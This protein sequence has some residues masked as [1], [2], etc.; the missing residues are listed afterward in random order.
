MESPPA[1]N[2]VFPMGLFR[3]VKLVAS[4]SVVVNDLF[5]TTK[6]LNADGTA[7][8][9]VSGTIKNSGNQDVA[10]TLD[11]KMA[12][13]N[14]AAEPLALPRQSINVH[15]G[16]N[17]FTREVVVKDPHLWWTWDLG[18]QNLYKLTATI[19]PAAGEGT[20][21]RTTVFGIRT[22]AR[23]SDMS[24]WLNGKR[25]FLK[26]A[27]YPIS[28]YYG[29]RPTRETYEKDLEMYKAANLNHLVAFTVVEKPD[30]YDLCDRLGI[31]EIFEFP[32]EQFG[33]IEVL[34]RFQPAPR[35]FCQGVAEPASADHC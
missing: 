32:F 14:F 26:G 33:P 24:Y 2:A 23:K 20:D 35:N 34:A 17:T 22:I 3:D 10:G 13:D 5:V 9:G 21:A 11:L 25:L 8:L 27:W 31:L 29:S 1:G 15:P 16:A 18:A 7:T 28:D 4:G 19:S 6:S 30:F 12:P